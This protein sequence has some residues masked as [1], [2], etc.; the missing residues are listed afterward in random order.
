MT[1]LAYVIK[2]VG[3]MDRAVAFHR[4]RLGLALRFASPEWS[5]FDTGTTTLALHLA[6]DE[7]PAGT[8]QLGYRV[9]DVGALYADL[10]AAGVASVQPP[11]PL[12]GQRIA[13][14]RDADG[15]EFSVS[16]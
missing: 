1:K 2:F 3:H 11:T 8:V 12:H 16:G 15:S 14:L 6:S 13:K 5:E 7:H 10:T 4:D 9:A